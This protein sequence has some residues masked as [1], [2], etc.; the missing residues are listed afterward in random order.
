MHISTRHT[1][2]RRTCYTQTY[3]QTIEQYSATHTTNTSTTLNAQRARTQRAP[4]IHTN[5]VVKGIC[6]AKA[7]YDTKKVKM[8]KKR[9]RDVVRRQSKI[10]PTIYFLSSFLLTPFFLSVIV[11]Q[12]V[13]Q[14][15][16][17]SATQS[18]AAPSSTMHP[19]YDWV[20]LTMPHILLQLENDL[21]D[22]IMHD[23][24]YERQPY[25]PST[26]D[27]ALDSRF[28]IEARSAHANGSETTPIEIPKTPSTNLKTKINIQPTIKHTHP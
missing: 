20:D 13:S 23:D 2:H 16:H 28:H 12:K 18:K 24:S 5:P 21:E 14:Q 1:Y 25:L 7:N 27:M 22:N 6:V 9:R 10:I 11:Q 8:V 17:I 3:T 15:T 19:D 4:T 26:M